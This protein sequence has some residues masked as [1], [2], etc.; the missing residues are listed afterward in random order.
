MGR[1]EKF[2]VPSLDGIRAIAFL[3]VFVAHAGLKD[4][5]PG[6]LGVTIF[7]FLSGYLITTLLRL[8]EDQTGTISLREFYIRRAIRILPPMY[9]TLA[10]VFILS[11]SGAMRTIPTLWSYVAAVLF[12]T[13]Y[14]SML[15][16]GVRWEGAGME[17]L[18]S[19]GVEEHFYLVFPL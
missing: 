5:V 4:I 11:H 2:Y 1:A 12:G 10:V 16:N 19:L 18:W 14:F 7:F 8:E 17:T 9:I 13:G 15:L 3:L 6:G